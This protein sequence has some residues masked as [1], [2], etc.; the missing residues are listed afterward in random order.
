MRVYVRCRPLPSY[1]QT[2][3]PR[4]THNI[5]VT[6]SKMEEIEQGTTTIAVTT[7]PS[8]DLNVSSEEIVVEKV[9]ENDHLN[10]HPSR[11]NI[12]HD[13][14]KITNAAIEVDTLLDLDLGVNVDGNVDVDVNKNHHHTRL[15]VHTSRYGTRRMEFDRVFVDNTTQEQIFQVSWCCCCCCCYF[16]C[17]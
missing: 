8:G 15:K 11:E 14:G 3:R 17:S 16:V 9:I 2:L 12:V 13:R 10:D 1:K 5:T 7:T 4:N 6:T